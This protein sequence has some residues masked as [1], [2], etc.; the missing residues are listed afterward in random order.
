MVLIQQ[1]IVKLCATDDSNLHDLALD[2][3]DKFDKYWEDFD[4]INQILMFTVVLDPR[5]KIG[6]LEYCFQNT[7][8]YDKTLVGL[9]RVLCWMDATEAGGGWVDTK[10]CVGF[11]MVV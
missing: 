11:V 7:L 2:M 8:G 5:C 10:T 3:S 6:F 9:V 4:K 1:G